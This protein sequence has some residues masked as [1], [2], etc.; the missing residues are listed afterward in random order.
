MTRLMMTK[1]RGVRTSVKKLMMS[2]QM[3]RRRL[4]EL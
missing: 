3:K 2:L 1:M 4:R